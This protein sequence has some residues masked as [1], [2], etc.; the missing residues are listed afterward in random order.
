M[1]KKIT[2]IAALL[3]A[4][5]L[6]LAGFP[7]CS[8]EDDDGDPTLDKI[9]IGIDEETVNT[10]YN[11]GE[12]FDKT[13]ITVTAKYSDGSTKNV[14]ADATFVATT[15]DGEFTTEAEGEFDV[16]LT[17]TYEGKTASVS[18]TITVKAGDGDDPDKP[19]DA[20]LS[21]I[22][23]AV[24]AT[25]KT[26]YTV[27]EAFDM[28]GITVTAKYSD[29]STKDVTAKATIVAKSG[30][31]D[32][33]TATAGTYEVTF[34][35]TYEGKTT[36]ATR[37]ITVKVNG[38]TYAWNFQATGLKDILSYSPSTAEATS[39]KDQL[40][41]EGT[42]ES[43]PAG[44]TLVLPK[45]AAFN[46]VDTGMS[47]SNASDIGAST[48]AIEPHESADI[49][50]KVR[51]PFTAV[52]LCGSNSST[53]KADRYAYIKVNGEEVAAP[54]KANTSLAL[55]E[56]LSY[57]Y[58]G[59]DE[60]TVAFGVSA[61][62]IRIYDIKITTEN[63]DGT[64]KTA[65]EVKSKAEFVATTDD[66]TAN[67]EA[68]LGLVGTKADSDTPAVATAAVENDKIV[69]TSVSAGSATITV[70]D[71]TEGHE[72]TIEVTVSGTGKI[73]IGKI[74]P[75]VDLASIFTVTDGVLEL[76]AGKSYVYTLNGKNFNDEKKPTAFTDAEWIAINGAKADKAMDENGK[77]GSP[78]SLNAST[79]RVLTVKVKGVKT[80]K[81]YATNGNKN[82]TNRC[83]SISIDNNTAETYVHDGRSSSIP[84]DFAAIKLDG[85]EHTLVIKG[86]TKTIYLTAIELLSE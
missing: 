2:R 31:A 36:S 33:T 9:E 49:S 67:D 18:R 81:L 27:G 19:G 14:T 16:T 65:G 61:N 86:G 60:V 23:I 68:T 39:G 17:A 75:Y 4:T 34:N 62:Y 12:E 63:G 8:D 48:G 52:M 11:I 66:T 3:A 82:D 58:T 46:K 59:T 38:T 22:E 41:A 26:E 77:Y 78:A 35:A 28:S 56:A 55:G 40:D 10:T 21:S 32:F 72:A 44:L 73:T 7:A 5:A 83:A 53:A 43:T 20:S 76:K 37:T 30:D 84:Y 1:M 85:E 51:G 47:A 80:F 69:I 13:G 6:L 54:G 29:D 57:T 42:Y 25:L 24:A 45:G 71:G 50:V 64:D 15:E 70:T 74:T 79:S